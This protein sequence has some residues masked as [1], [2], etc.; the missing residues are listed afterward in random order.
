MPF[1]I[2]IVGTGNLAW[3]LAS[4]LAT[5]DHSIDA[6]ASR[7]EDR[8]RS[9]GRSLNLHCHSILP[10]HTISSDFVLFCVSDEA[11]ETIVSEY[12]YAPST[13]L[14]HCS[15][16]TDLTVF[17]MDL[18]NPVGV[19]YPFQTFT[20]GRPTEFKE[21][22]LFLEVRRQQDSGKL[23]TFASSLS[24][25]VSF[26]NGEAR[27]RLHMAGVYASNFANFMWW[28]AEQFLTESKVDFAAV[29]KLV[30]ETLDK[31]FEIGPKNAQTGPAVR[32][33]LGIQ[34]KHLELLAGPD[35]KDLYRLLSKSI[36]MKI[37]SNE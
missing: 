27:L 22:P 28:Q 31:A 3:H 21:V 16:A 37:G 33:D 12:S 25:H 11:L 34:Q 10:G 32:G 13:V 36:F 17:P 5:G 9:F 4:A 7:D 18:N 35:E 6:I 29:K 2:T 14:V 30:N 8:A 26:L 15:G 1:S 20:K 23:V 19:M 24:D